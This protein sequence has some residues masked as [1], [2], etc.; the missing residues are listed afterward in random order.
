MPRRRRWASCRGGALWSSAAAAPELG[1]WGRIV[2]GWLG[3]DEGLMV[4]R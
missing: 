3:M 4:L 1:N 2:R